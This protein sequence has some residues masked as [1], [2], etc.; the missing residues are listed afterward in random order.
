MLHNRPFRTV[1]LSASVLLVLAT[2]G[3]GGGQPGE[4]E[5]RAAVIDRLRMEADTAT[6]TTGM[7]NQVRL[8]ASLRTGCD[9]IEIE[10]RGRCTLDDTIVWIIRD[11]AV[12]RL[13]VYTSS[14]YD[15]RDTAAA[16]LLARR[17]G[18]TWVVVRS[19]QRGLVDS[20]LLVVEPG[21]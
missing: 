10:G 4:Y 18:R 12:A 20:T 11:T 14:G 9:T 6:A 5:E 13:Y 7:N 2:A 3:C 17:S 19:Q 1:L 8:R 15:G 16:S 21:T